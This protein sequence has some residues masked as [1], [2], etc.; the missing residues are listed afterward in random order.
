MKAAQWSEQMSL[1]IGA[2]DVAHKKF[3]EDLSALLTVPDDTF[4]KAFVAF[5]AQV[6]ADFREEE[7]LME[8]LDYAGMKTHVEQHARVLGALHHVVPRV[9]EGDIA[10]GRQA[11]DL[12]PQWFLVHLSTMDAA[13]ACALELT[14]SASE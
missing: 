3:M 8:D 14:E 2:M 7:R 5:V 9:L 12:L 1:G 10:L 6:E 11:V 4:A 13:L